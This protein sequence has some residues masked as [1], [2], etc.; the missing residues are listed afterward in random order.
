MATPEQPRNI[1]LAVEA[2]ESTAQNETYRNPLFDFLD[3]PQN[4]T[5]VSSLFI[6]QETMLDFH[7]MDDFG[8]Y[9]NGQRRVDSMNRTTGV[10]CYP[11]IIDASLSGAPKAMLE[12]VRYVLRHYPARSIAFTFASGVTDTPVRKV[13]EPTREEMAKKAAKAAMAES[14]WPAKKS[15]IERVDF[16]LTGVLPEDPLDEAEEMF[17]KSPEDFTVD[18]IRRAKALGLAGVVGSAEFACL[19]EGSKVPYIGSG[20]NL[21]GESY[22]A[23]GVTKR[24][25]PYSEAAKHCS[26]VVVGHYISGH[27]DGFDVALK[28]LEA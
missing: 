14:K 21:T 12:S 7:R 18:T 19:A 6:P 27:P 28:S 22:D 25:T 15:A 5:R 17:G 8:S 13:V 10:P 24:A 20:V 2:F 11:V 26:Q 3:N 1:S 23:E 4:E 16:L 9:M